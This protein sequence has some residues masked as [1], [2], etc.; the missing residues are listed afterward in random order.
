LAPQEV[1][2]TMIRDHAFKYIIPPTGRRSG[3]ENVEVL[4]WHTATPGLIIQTPLLECGH[5]DGKPSTFELTHEPSGCIIRSGV[6]YERARK[7]AAALSGIPINFT[8]VKAEDV[9]LQLAKATNSTLEIFFAVILERKP[10]KEVRAMLIKKAAAHSER[11]A[12]L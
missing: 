7:I 6:E 1:E 3:L 12:R 5:P 10:P 8:C 2:M 4:A 9:Y 11:L